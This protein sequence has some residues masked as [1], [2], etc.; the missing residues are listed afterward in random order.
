VPYYNN[1][2]P[3]LPAAPLSIASTIDTL[4]VLP[5]VP[6]PA[7]TITL[8]IACLAVLC[9]LRCTLLSKLTYSCLTLP[10]ALAKALLLA[11]LLGI[12]VTADSLA[13]LALAASY[14]K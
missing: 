5:P 7:C 3:P 13:L 9:L 14:L 4:L 12:V 2:L 10:P 11:V 6:S 8:C 1:T